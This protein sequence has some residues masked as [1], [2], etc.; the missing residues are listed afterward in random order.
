VKGTDEYLPVILPE[1]VGEPDVPHDIAGGGGRRSRAWRVGSFGPNTAVRYSLDEVRRKSRDQVRKNPYAAFAVDR[2]VSNIIGTGIT[3]KSAAPH[4][5]FR[6]AVAKLWLDWTDQADS[7][8]AHDF[9]GLQALAV[10]GMVEGGE[11]FTRLRT[12]LPSD[13]LVVPLQLQVLEGDHC[14][15]LKDD[16]AANIRAGIQYGAIGQRLGYWMH[17]EHPGDGVL[18]GMP[19]IEQALVPAEDI[20]H[21]Y[22]SLRPGQDRGEPWLT[23]ALRTLYDLD[24]YLDAELVRKK[25]AAML[26]GFIRR[27]ADRNDVIGAGPAEADGSAGLALEPGTMQVLLD[28]EDVTFSDPKDVGANFEP[29]VRQ[30]L[31]GVSAAAGLLYEELSG[32]YSN[33]NDRTLRAALNAFRRQAEAWQHHLVVYQFCRR[34]WVRW[35]DLALLSGALR[36]PPGM[37]RADAYAVDWLPTRWPYVHPVQDITAQSAE[38]QAGFATRSQ[39]VSERGYDAAAIDAENAADNARADGLKLSYTSDGRT[40]A[41]A[42][43]AGSRDRNPDEDDE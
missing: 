43:D 42:S 4:E 10:R 1:R 12:R 3:P 22:R 20:A 38:V 15:H 9:Y 37:A 31:R 24:A 25:T 41:K 23:R 6:R 34:V 36:L 33:L 2:L 40:K 11:T 7:V 26:V 19:A 13:G 32:D 39:K 14:P 18:A 17:R 30:A 35:I 16:A 21:L 8:G 28:G 5:G 29:F 27:P